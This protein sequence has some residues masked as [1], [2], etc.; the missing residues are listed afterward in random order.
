MGSF[1]EPWEIVDGVYPQT[2]RIATVDE[3]TLFT[4][5]EKHADRITTCV[6]SCENYEHP[7]K[8][9]ELIKACEGLIK[10]PKCGKEKT[11]QV[12]MDSGYW[13][14]PRNGGCG[15]YFMPY[16]EIEAALAAVQDR[17]AEL[18]AEIE[19]PEK[20][21]ELMEAAREYIEATHGMTPEKEKFVAAYLAVKGE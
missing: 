16:E 12:D 14:V 7:E 3:T 18:E 8:L 1:G 6:N 10:C 4:I 15:H 17:I 20:I 13:C 19:H 9:P 5:P 21:P 2:K 11:Y